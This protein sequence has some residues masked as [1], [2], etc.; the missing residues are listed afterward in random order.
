MMRVVGK[1]GK[2]LGPKKLMPNP[3]EGSVTADVVTAVREFKGGKAKYRVDEGGNL[4]AIFGKR[5]GVERVHTLAGAAQLD[6]DQP[7]VTGNIA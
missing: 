2:V 4:H 5:P 6:V 1:L 3:K 7:F